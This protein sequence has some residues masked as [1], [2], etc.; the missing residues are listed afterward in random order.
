[1]VASRR[2]SSPA[3]SIAAAW[4]AAISPTAWRNPFRPGDHW[5]FR[6]VERD[7]TNAPTPS[8]FSGHLLLGITIPHQGPGEIH[9]HPS[10]GVPRVPGLRV[11]RA[12]VEL[13][14]VP[15]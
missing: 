11:G 7:V 5:R 15:S 9:H 1:M 6:N 10:G 8:P 3:Q 14:Q 13:L 4:A 12:E 2:L